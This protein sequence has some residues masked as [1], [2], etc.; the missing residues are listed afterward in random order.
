[1]GD[2]EVS[3]IISHDVGGLEDKDKSIMSL[4]VTYQ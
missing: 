3:L 1:V 2:F 4:K